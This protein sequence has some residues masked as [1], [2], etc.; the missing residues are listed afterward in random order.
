MALLYT[1]SSKIV[2]Y[3]MG[4]Y[5]CVRIELSPL[6]SLVVQGIV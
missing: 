4:G 6:Q 3:C 2:L 5:D 1:T